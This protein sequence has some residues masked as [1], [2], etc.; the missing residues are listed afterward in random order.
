MRDGRKRWKKGK[1]GKTGVN[2]SEQREEKIRGNKQRDKNKRLREVFQEFIKWSKKESGYEREK[3][4]IGR[5]EKRSHK[6]GEDEEGDRKTKR[7]ECYADR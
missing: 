5:R 3:K 4:N 7:W 1:T 6:Q 2:V